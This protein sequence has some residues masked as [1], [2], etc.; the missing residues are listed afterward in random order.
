MSIGPKQDAEAAPMFF[1]SMFVLQG[2]VGLVGAI[3]ALFGTLVAAHIFPGLG[4]TPIAAPITVAI[5]SSQTHDFLRRYFFSVGRVQVSFFLD[6]TRYIGQILAILTLGTWFPASGT[7]ALWL[8]SIG[9]VVAVLVTLPFIPRLKYSTQGIIEVGLHSWH[10]SKWLAGSTLLG[11]AF[12]NLFTFAVGALLDAAAVGAMRAAF[13]L[14]SITN[15]VVEAFGNVVPVSSSRELMSN[16]RSGL[17]A[18]LRKIAIYGAAAMG[19]LLAIIVVGAKFW[20]HLF[21]GSEF[22]PYSDLIVWYAV[23][24]SVTFLA[25]VI[26]AF[27]RTL[28]STRLIFAAYAFSALLSL[29]IAYPLISNFGLK[30]AMFGLLTGQLAQLLFM[31]IVGAIPAP[32]R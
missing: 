19:C 23:I 15:L 21:F 30:G 24:Q 12:A 31:L 17:I 9:A 18:Y 14:V 3:L 32:L 5:I 28:E 8:I 7:A 27:Y 16:G 26:G 4:L 25:F 1:G 22:E 2:L 11:F 13:A 29:A 20:L 6:A 10:F